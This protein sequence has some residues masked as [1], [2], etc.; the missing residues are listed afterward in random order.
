MPPKDFRKISH[1]EPK[2]LNSLVNCGRTLTQTD[3]RS[4][5][6]VEL[7]PLPV[8]QLTKTRYHVT[9]CFENK[10][11]FHIIVTLWSILKE[12]TGNIYLVGQ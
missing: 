7:T 9:G 1:L 2:I 5:L 6:D 4:R 3:R 12:I 8:G 11:L 10:L